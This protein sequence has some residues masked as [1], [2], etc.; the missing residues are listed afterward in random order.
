MANDT[1]N[2]I[3]DLDPS[4]VV[5]ETV[6]DLVPVANTSLAPATPTTDENV[7]S[8]LEEDIQYARGTIRDGISEMR[9]ATKSAIL[10]AQSGDSPRAFEVV[11]NMLNAIVNANKE[12]VNLHKTREETTTMHR[13][14]VQGTNAGAG[15]GGVNIEK[16]VF[17]GRAADLLRE[18]R[19][20]PVPSEPSTDDTTE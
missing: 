19:N 17:V 2:D 13:A 9:E 11:G 16:A 18:L 5:V 15:G 6:T 7:L 20:L 10:L 8:E 12:L 3:F 14:R 4:M 1:L